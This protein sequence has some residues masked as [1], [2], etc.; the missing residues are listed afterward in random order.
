[1]SD[2]KSS[3]AGQERLS[4]W[5]EIW[6][7]RAVATWFWT[8]DIIPVQVRQAAGDV[9]VVQVIPERR[10]DYKKVGHEGLGSPQ[11]LRTAD[12][13]FEGRQSSSSFFAFLFWAVKCSLTYPFPFFE[14]SDGGQQSAHSGWWFARCGKISHCNRP[15]LA[16]CARQSSFIDIG[17][18]YIVLLHQLDDEQVI[19]SRRKASSASF[20]RITVKVRNASR[21]FDS[22]LAKAGDGAGCR[23]M[24]GD[25]VQKCRVGSL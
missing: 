24:T 9:L 7:F 18:T 4:I 16:A 21:R 13:F 1:M 22:H 12:E 15:W 5:A 6:T 10:R 14:V 19:C 2:V 3:Q 23:P 20:R 25:H 17:P 8:P 11:G